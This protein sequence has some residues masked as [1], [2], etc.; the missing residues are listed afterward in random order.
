[1]RDRMMGL[2]KRYD[3][4]KAEEF[5]KMR[6]NPKKLT[7]PIMSAPMAVHGSLMRQP[8]SILSR[9]VRRARF[10]NWCSRWS[11]GWAFIF[12]AFA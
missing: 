12:C 5:S 7:S 10:S 4:R 2:A 11:K 3:D 8:A 9:L 1:M 6:A